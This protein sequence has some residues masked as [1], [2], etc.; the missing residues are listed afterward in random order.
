MPQTRPGTVIS[1]PWSTSAYGLLEPGAEEAERAGRVEDDE[2]GADLLGERV[3]LAA[4]DGVGQQ[5]RLLAA[6]DPEGL[7]RHP[8]R[9]RRR[10]AW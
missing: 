2:L 7:R 1:A 4:Q 8:T 5:H 3:D 6:H 10:G 9:R